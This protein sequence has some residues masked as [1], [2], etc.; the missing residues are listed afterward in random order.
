MGAC[1]PV[2]K[3]IAENVLVPVEHFITEARESCEYAQTW[4]EEQ[5]W[6]PVSQ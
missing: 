2:S 6:Q 1:K 4:I 3:W 5:I